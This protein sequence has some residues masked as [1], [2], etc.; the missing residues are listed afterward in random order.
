M[1]HYQY[2]DTCHFNNFEIVAGLKIVSRSPNP[3]GSH[4][5]LLNLTP[6]RERVCDLFRG[7]YSDGNRRLK[8]ARPSNLPLLPWNHALL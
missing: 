5:E 6:F 1:K 7:E 2:Y 8:N 3:I 4:L